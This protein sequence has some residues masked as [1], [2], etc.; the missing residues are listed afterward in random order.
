MALL[1]LR[2]LRVMSV[3]SV[4]LMVACGNSAPTEPTPISSHRGAWLGPL[5]QTSCTAGDPR[6]CGFTFPSAS[7]FTLRLDLV[8]G[9]TTVTGAFDLNTVPP[10]GA[11]APQRR[12]VGSL[13]GTVAADGTLMLEGPVAQ[14]GTAMTATISRWRSRIEADG[15]MSGS[16]T[17]TSPGGLG[18]D[19]LVVVFDL[20]AVRRVQ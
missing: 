5:R 19:L 1:R 16:F 9:E 15:S 14:S 4:L 17:Y 18:L 13:S 10:Q 2:I 20:V 3:W 11:I 8:P 12:D 6:T 7:T